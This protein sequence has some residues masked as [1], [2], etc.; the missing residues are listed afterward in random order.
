MKMRGEGLACLVLSLCQINSCMLIPDPGQQPI[1]YSQ[2]S[3]RTN[4]LTERQCQHGRDRTV[5]FEWCLISPHH[6]W[7][8]QHPNRVQLFYLLLIH[9]CES[10]GFSQRH[11]HHG[12]VSLHQ[13]I[14]QLDL[15]LMCKILLPS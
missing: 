13:M 8:H 10:L 15:A 6:S 11:L 7:T 4:K 9:S 1:T 2:M 5:D 12:I 3:L 14:T